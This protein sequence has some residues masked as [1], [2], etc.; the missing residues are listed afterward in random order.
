MCGG[1]RPPRNALYTGKCESIVFRHELPVGST[2]K[3]KD[4]P[5]S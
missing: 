5:L 2:L 4:D 1:T 3:T